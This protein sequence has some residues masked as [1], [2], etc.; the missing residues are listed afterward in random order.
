MSWPVMMTLKNLGRPCGLAALTMCAVVSAACGGSSSPTSP[1]PSTPSAPA[2]SPTFSSINSQIFASRCYQCHGTNRREQNLD[3]QN[4]GYANLV[5][6]ASTQT[7]LQLVVPGNPD[8]SYLLHKVDGRAGISGQRMP[9]GQAVLSA[10]QI[11]AIRT[12]IQ[13]GAANN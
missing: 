9:L 3:L 2:L 8:Q 10:E 13:N 6:R 12:W 11:A 1:T 4:N 7:S 5:N